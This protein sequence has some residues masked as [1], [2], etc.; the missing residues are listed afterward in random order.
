MSLAAAK[1]AAGIVKA[2]LEACPD[3][4]VIPTDHGCSPL[5]LAAEYCNDAQGVEAVRLLLEAAPQ[6]CTVGWAGW[7]GVA[8]GAVDCTG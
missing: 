5:S 8:S 4:A 7:V 6:M 1:G 3:C 2:M